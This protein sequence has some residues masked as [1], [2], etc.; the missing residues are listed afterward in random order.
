M[1]NGWPDY[2]WISCG[3]GGQKWAKL[4]SKNTV[5]LY[6][7]KCA[8]E[9]V[10]PHKE[11]T[12]RCSKIF[13]QVGKQCTLRGRHREGPSHQCRV[14]PLSQVDHGR[15]RLWA[16]SSAPD[17]ARVRSR[18]HRAQN[19]PSNQEN[20]I[21]TVL[22]HSTVLRLWVIVYGLHHYPIRDMQAVHSAKYYI[23]KFYLY[24]VS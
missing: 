20:T 15:L 10:A 11:T 14:S 24:L 12:T 16:K 4:C 13:A 18:L 2:A 21:T 5:G 7:H 19:Q 6:G 8:V 17:F 9:A 3:L 23:V 1:G 22:I